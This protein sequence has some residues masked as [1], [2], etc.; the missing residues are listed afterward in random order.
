MYICLP[1]VAYNCLRSILLFFLHGPGPKISV[2]WCA[3][4]WNH[5]CI[6]SRL[7][8][9][10]HLHHD[11]QPGVGGYHFYHSLW[12]HCLCAIPPWVLITPIKECPFKYCTT[13]KLRCSHRVCQ[14]DINASSC[15]L[16]PF[17]TCLDT[18]RDPFPVFIFSD[19]RKY[20]HEGAWGRSITL[21]SINASAVLRHCG[22]SSS[23][24][25]FFQVLVW[26]Q[27][28]SSGFSPARS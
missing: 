18:E 25:T 15:F 6:I 19:K 20:L 4:R 17:D 14:E 22:V 28:A 26:G 3:E 7:F 23:S 2:W 16:L 1:V 11:G 8:L 24:S 21:S 27:G 9:F 12:S 10:C 5:L 13:P